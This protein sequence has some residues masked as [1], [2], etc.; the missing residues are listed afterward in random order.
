MGEDSPVSDGGSD[1]IQPA[2]STPTASQ[3][4]APARLVILAVA[5]VVTSVLAP[6][7]GA[8]L[9]L[10][11]LVLAL[12]ARSVG[13][14]LRVTVALVGAGAML[15]GVAVSAV[16]IAFRT[17]ITDY[18]ACLQGANTRLAEQACQQNLND[19]LGDRLG[20]VP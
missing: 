20:F 4:A 7:V 17:E 2:A 1:P 5:A 9:G 19:A 11:T 14:G 12:R 16:A 6:P 18:S 10:L 15:V 3:R 8:L 13:P